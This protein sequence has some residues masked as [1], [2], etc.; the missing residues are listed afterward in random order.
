MGG[1]RATE[2]GGRAGDGGAGAGFAVGGFA[3]DAGVFFGD[4]VDVRLNSV[5]GLAGGGEDGGARREENKRP[6]RE[7]I[8][9]LFSLCTSCVQTYRVLTGI[10]SR[11]ARRSQ[12]GKKFPLD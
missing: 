2:G 7:L 5:D 10:V 4:E 12:S 6:K 1:A 9:A 8:T 11:R 3:G